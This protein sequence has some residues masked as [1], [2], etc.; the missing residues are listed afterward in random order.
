M[1][2]GVASM[3]AP[4]P[5]GVGEAGLADP[6]VPQ[7]LVGDGVQPVR[8]QRQMLSPHQ[9]GEALGK[10]EIV[11]ALV[12]HGQIPHGIKGNRLDHPGGDIQNQKLDLQLVMDKAGHPRHL[13]GMGLDTIVLYRR[14]AGFV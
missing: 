13:L 5:H 4:Q 3:G 11:H 1:R 10:V 2:F 9:I 7:A 12:A 6:A 14:T 8:R